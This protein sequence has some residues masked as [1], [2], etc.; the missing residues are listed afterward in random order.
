MIRGKSGCLWISILSSEVF[1]VVLSL[2][3]CFLPLFFLRLYSVSLCDT[4]SIGSMCLHPLS[5][6]LMWSF[7]FHFHMDLN[8]EAMG[9]LLCS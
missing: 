1:G 6:A 4:T 2:E 8:D 5:Y 3:N 7:G 9:D